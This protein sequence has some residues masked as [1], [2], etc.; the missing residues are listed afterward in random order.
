SIVTLLLL[1]DVE[2]L[3]AYRFWQVGSLA[4]RGVEML[5]ALWPFIA[6]GAVLALLSGRS[7]NLLAFGD[8]VARGLGHSGAR[9]RIATAIAVVLLCG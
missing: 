8:D 6:V 5:S 7:L 9:T 2:T 1:T 4:G 3:N